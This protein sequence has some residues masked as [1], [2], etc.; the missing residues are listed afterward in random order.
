MSSGGKISPI[1]AGTI[2]DMILEVLRLQNVSADDTQM[3]LDSSCSLNEILK[4]DNKIIYAEGGIYTDMTSTLR[5]IEP[6]RIYRCRLCARSFLALDQFLAHLQQ[7][8]STTA[9]F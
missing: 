5:S 7:R 4:T 2:G 6:R 1:N 9:S 3:F 8:H